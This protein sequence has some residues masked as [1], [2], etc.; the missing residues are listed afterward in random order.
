MAEER[1]ELPRD[2]VDVAGLLAWLPTL[3][4]AHARAFDRPGLVR[5]AVNQAFATGADPVRDG[6]E[7]AL[8]PPVTGG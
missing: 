7:V 1:L 3:D 6:D 2:V 8:F 4:A 5:C